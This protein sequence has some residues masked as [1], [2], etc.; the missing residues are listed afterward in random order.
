MNTGNQNPRTSGRGVIKFESTCAGIPCIVDVYSFGAPPDSRADNDWDFY[1]A[2]P[3]WGICDLQGRPA[4]WLED[5]LTDD[6]W[7]RIDQEVSEHRKD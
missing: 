6:D 4:P 7:C 1:G 2:P 5:K 3:E